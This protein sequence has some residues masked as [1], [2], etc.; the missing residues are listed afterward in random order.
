MKLEVREVKPTSIRIYLVYRS[1]AYARGIVEDVL[2]NV[3]KF[4]F[5]ADFI[6]LHRE[7]G[8]DIQIRGLNRLF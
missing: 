8:V 4:N 5:P 3:N 2:V 6:V 1:L 7:E